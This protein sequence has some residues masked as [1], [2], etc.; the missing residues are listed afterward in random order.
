MGTSGPGYCFGGPSLW[1]AG[2]SL[3]FLSFVGFEGPAQMYGRSRFFAMSNRDRSVDPLD[4]IL[5]DLNELALATQA[6]IASHRL[7]MF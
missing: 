1:A 6:E 3:P 2:R 7:A 5:E 4:P